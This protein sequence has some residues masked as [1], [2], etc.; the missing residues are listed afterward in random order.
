MADNGIK[1]M[2]P[3][4]QNVSA[5]IAS[6][7]PKRLPP[8]VFVDN[9]RPLADNQHGPVTNLH[10]A[11]SVVV[12]ETA[13]TTE[14]VPQVETETVDD[15]AKR[16]KRKEDWDMAA[17]ARQMQA[18]AT[19]KLKKAQAYD[20][21]VANFDKDPLALAKILGVSVPELLDKMQRAAFSMPTERVLTPEETYKLKT[22]QYEQEMQQIKQQQINMNNQIIKDNFVNKRVIPELVK[23]PDKYEIIHADLGVDQA[24]N[25]IFNYI[26]EQ[27]LATGKELDPAD[28]CQSFEE[29]LE[30][31]YRNNATKLKSV[32]KF[33]D[34]FAAEK[35]QAEAEEAAAEEAPVKKVAAPKTEVAANETDLA[36]L[37]SPRGASVKKSQDNTISKGKT[38]EQR[39]AEMAAKR[40]AQGQ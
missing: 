28:V 12:Q 38:R 1:V 37:V 22:M 8:P 7:N 40:E 25:F 23:N 30:E 9:G 26:A 35:A 36:K 13:T 14:T 33:K 10:K 39:L 31:T 15:S 16:H 17:K 4:G 19:E 20:A 11:E 2:P 27:Y 29:E 18:D 6:I 21:A 32:K 3:M 34:L 5:T 24:A